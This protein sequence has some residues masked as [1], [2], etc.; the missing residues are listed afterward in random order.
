MKMLSFNVFKT[1]HNRSTSSLQNH[2][3]VNLLDCKDTVDM[4]HLCILPWLVAKRL[5]GTL[6]VIMMDTQVI[7]RQQILPKDVKFLSKRQVYCI[8]WKLL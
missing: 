3:E 7:T 8:L 1:N 4:K 5:E 6:I 2:P